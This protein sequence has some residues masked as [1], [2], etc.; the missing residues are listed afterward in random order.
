MNYK[1][2]IEQLESKLNEL[3]EELSSLQG[4]CSLLGEQIATSEHKLKELAHKK[5]V[6]RKSVELLTLVQ[7]ATK[8][9]IKEGFE[10]IVTYA[11][12]YIYNDDYAFELEFGRRGNLQEIDFNVKTPDFKEA[13][14]PK[15]T[16]GGGVLDILSL[17]LRIALLELAKPKIEGFVIL[18]EP[19]KHLSKDYLQ[20]S[21]EFL[22]AINKRIN[23]QII[24]VTHKEEMLTNA[25]NIIEIK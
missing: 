18:D 8:E 5:E 12:R 20:R 17:A 22:K 25:D 2:E 10:N 16:S 7:K 15:D 21:G 24:M 4:K 9:K 3:K 14:D 23:R 11:L 19:F 13:F 6:Y 1:S